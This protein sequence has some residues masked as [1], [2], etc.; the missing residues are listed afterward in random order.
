MPSNTG[1]DPGLVIGGRMVSMECEQ[2]MM[3][4]GLCP[5]WG[6]GAETQVRGLGFC[7]LKLKAFHLWNVKIKG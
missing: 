1:P 7:P 5:Q 6:P 3:V 4:W 2:I